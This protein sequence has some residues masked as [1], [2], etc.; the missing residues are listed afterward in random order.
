[1]IDNTNDF[2]LLS[3]LMNNKIDELNNDELIKLYSTM[4]SKYFTLEETDNLPWL[5][6]Y[7][8]TTTKDL[9]H[10]NEQVLHKFKIDILIINTLLY[11]LVFKMS[12][13]EKEIKLTVDEFFKK[14]NLQRE[15]LL[16]DKIVICIAMILALNNEKDKSDIK[17]QIE[18]SV[19][20]YNLPKDFKKDLN[21]R[22]I[23]L[24]EIEKHIYVTDNQICF[25]AN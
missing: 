11:D 22:T 9:S 6:Y 18:N 7:T 19:F 8:K 17:T 5:K 16:Y 4:I 21:S 14:L 13:T 24:N 10:I 3:K 25:T 15:P 20:I 1:M 23:L 12:N 2:D